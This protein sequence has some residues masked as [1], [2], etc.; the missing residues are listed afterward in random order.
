MQA[1]TSEQSSRQPASLGRPLR[2]PGGSRIAH[3]IVSCIVGRTVG[4]AAGRTVG[5]TVG[6]NAGRPVGCPVGCVVHR[7][8]YRGSGVIKT[9]DG[10]LQALDHDLVE[11]RVVGD[12]FLFQAADDLARDPECLARIGRILV[13]DLKHTHLF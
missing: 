8:V 3:R 2:G 11:G 13:L 7:I 4:R 5:R 9:L 10:I 6:C 12:S 1:D